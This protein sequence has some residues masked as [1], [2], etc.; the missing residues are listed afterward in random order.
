MGEIVAKI[1]TLSNGIKVVSQFMP[2]VSSCALGVWAPIGSRF[3]KKTEA[4][5]SHFIEH[6]AF[7]G[8][9]TRTAKQISEEIESVGGYLNA[10]T[11]RDATAWY[12]KV[13]KDDMPKAMEI[14]S[15]ILLN[16]TF[17]EKEL[18]VERTV[19]L[20]EIAQSHD[21][22][23]DALYDAFQ[24]ACYSQQPLGQPILGSVENVS[25]FSR[26]S[27]LSW[28]KNQHLK[29]E[30]IIAASG[31]VDHEEFV[32]KAQ[33]YFDILAPVEG[34]D[35]APSLWAAEERLIARDLEQVQFVLGFNGYAYGHDNWYAAAVFSSLFGGSMSSRLFQEIRENLGLVY[36]IGS[37]HSSHRDGGC[38]GIQAAT[39]P[40][41]IQ[42][43]LKASALEL[44]KV[45]KDLQAHEI[46]RAKTQL[47]AGIL[48]SLENVSSRVEQIARQ[49]MVFDHILDVKEIEEKIE[50]VSLGQITGFIDDI[51]DDSIAF[52]A[53]GKEE[54]L[55]NKEDF[56]KYLD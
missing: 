50:Q 8:T 15:D 32:A 18:E 31:N 27:L 26:K 45:K 29:S 46:K 28:L 36:G 35:Y 4:G 38:F 44:S 3:E 5:I 39:T 6:M 7:K 30:F 11:S 1:T 53:I 19:I 48:M 55:P 20:Q 51:L 24:E 33:K 42:K 34:R 9:H 43:V 40:E 37:F 47:K 14:I 17:D 23:D 22:P 41:N 13:L 54:H 25:S 21:A 49:M 56:T 52:A 12:S 2:S 10:W 16:P